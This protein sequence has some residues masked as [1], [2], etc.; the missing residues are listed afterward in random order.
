V[1]GAEVLVRW[2]HPQD[3]LLMPDRFVPVAE[4]CGLIRPL[5]QWTLE[6]ALSQ[7]GA[8]RRGALSGARPQLWFALNVSAHELAQGDVYVAQLKD[9][10]EANGVP[11]SC[12]ELEVT[13]RVLMSHLA[14]NVATLRKIGDLG[15]RVAI[16]DF[17]TG[18]SSLAYLTRFPLAS[19]KI[20]RSFVSQV[21]SGGADATIVRSII[22]MAHTL[23]FTVVAEGV[24]SGPQ[25]DFLRSLGCEHAQGFLFARPMPVADFTAHMAGARARSQPKPASRRRPA[26]KK[27]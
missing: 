20:D 26:K 1:V 27:G 6:R 3:G 13:E 22:D 25:A 21:L 7:I 17:G 24:E 19:L 5:G 4:D 9:A 12:I 14:E 16:D 8:W 11:G 23:G 15:V 2:Q 18:Y 10:L